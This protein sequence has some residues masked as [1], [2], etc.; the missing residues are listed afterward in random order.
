LTLQKLLG[1]RG[2]SWKDFYWG[3]EK[4]KMVREKM[5]RKHAKFKRIWGWGK[6][7][8]SEHLTGFWLVKRKR[9]VSGR[10][11]GGGGVEA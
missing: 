6:I 2:K 3:C 7:D 4:R 5:G 11:G 8:I 9:H 1:S 10:T